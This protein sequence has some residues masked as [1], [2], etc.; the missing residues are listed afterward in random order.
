M[1]LCGN[2]KNKYWYV[3]AILVTVLIFLAYIW[4]SSSAQAGLCFCAGAA[5]YRVFRI[6]K[7]E[8]GNQKKAFIN[9]GIFTLIV[10]VLLVVS[11]VAMK[12]H[13]ND[14]ELA[15]YYA[16]RKS[17]TQYL[18]YPGIINY[19]DDPALYESL[20]ISEHLEK[21]AKHWFFMDDAIT[22]DAFNTLAGVEDP[23]KI[24]SFLD[25][26]LSPVDALKTGYGLFVHDAEARWILLASVFA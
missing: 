24:E 19:V 8:E 3:D 13:T 14:P 15:D 10:A 12:A 1:I 9:L 22:A 20:G 21:L 2:F 6:W 4:R 25:T 26:H 18:D 17:C 11:E 23:D 16:F 5:V 7:N